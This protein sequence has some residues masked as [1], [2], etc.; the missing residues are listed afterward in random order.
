MLQQPSPKSIALVKRHHAQAHQVQQVAVWSH[1]SVGDGWAPDDIAVAE[2]Q[3]AHQ[4]DLVQ[5]VV[6]EQ[7]LEL[8]ESVYFL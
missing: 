5:S 2:L 4:P 1:K 7:V 3:L 6:E 8:Y